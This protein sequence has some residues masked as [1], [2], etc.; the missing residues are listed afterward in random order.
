[1]AKGFLEGYKTYDAADGFGSPKD[2]QKAFKQRMGKDEAETILQDGEQTPYGILGIGTDA[3]KEVIKKAYRKMIS[4]WHPDHN[5]HRI[6]E[7]EE[8][9]KKIVAAYTIL[10][11]K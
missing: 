2:W 1:M 11:S 4:L 3:T 9:S 8:M 6:T 5:Q 7:A 10:K